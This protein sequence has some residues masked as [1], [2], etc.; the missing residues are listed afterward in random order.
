[1]LC[2]GAALS[3]LE[4]PFR[5]RP[6]NAGVPGETLS[7]LSAGARQAGMGNTGV[8]STG[9]E[10]AYYNP[11]GIAGSRVGEVTFMSSPL[12]QGGQM[13][14]LSF[15]YPWANHDHMGVM[16]YQLESGDAEKTDSFGQTL[17]NFSE[18]N[19]LMTG[20]YARQVAGWLDAGVGLKWVRQSL[21]DQEG[22][23][24]GADAGVALN[25]FQNRV[26][27]GV[28]MQNVI[29]PSIK[30]RQETEHFERVMRVG[31]MTN[32]PVFGRKLMLA[33]DVSSM[34]GATR[35][36]AGFQLDLVEIRDSLLL[37]RWGMNQ[38]EYTMGFGIVQ[39]PLVLDYAVSVNEINMMHR[40]GITFKYGLFQ[41]FSPS[42]LERKKKELAEEERDIRDMKSKL[43]KEKKVLD[44]ESDLAELRAKALKLFKEER[45]DESNKIA[46][47][48]LRTSPNDEAATHMIQQVRVVR[49]RKRSSEVLSSA[50]DLYQQKKYREVVQRIDSNSDIF[51]ANAEA[52]ILLNLSRARLAID[53]EK[54]ND[55]EEA[56]FKV[57]ES[58]PSNEEAVVLYK[59]LKEFQ[60]LMSPEGK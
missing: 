59:R 39:G 47:E 30:L 23:G 27:L 31:L 35:W 43:N 20:T 25:A 29:A 33:Q 5:S 49:E 32:V 2:H 1:V 18:K 53:A 24:Y 38:R 34:G 10:S 50:R 54:Y 51:S 9:A 22:G 44:Q 37:L 58:D 36:G 17:G 11:A 26:R 60:A 13:N 3:A 8:A 55:A 12:L 57:I 41:S 6:E 42:A 48:I 45:Y 28:S 52:Q 40:F 46:Y 21:S 15:M 14:A 19:I 7:M 4:V 56:L 16:I